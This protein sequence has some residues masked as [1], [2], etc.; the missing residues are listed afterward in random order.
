MVYTSDFRHF[1]KCR[2]KDKKDGFIYFHAM[3]YKKNMSIARMKSH[4]MLANS[5]FKEAEKQDF[6]LLWV[7]VPPNSFVKAGSK[8]KKNHQ[9]VKL[10][11]DLIDLWPE[12]MPISKFK[13]LPPFIFWKNLRDK[14][15]NAADVIVT[16]CDL[17][18]QKLP[19][20]IKEKLHT[21][22]LARKIKEENNQL[23]LPEDRISLCYLGSINNIIDIAVITD[24]IKT[25]KAYKNVEIHIVGDGEKRD[26][27]ISACENVGAEVI[28][29]GRVYEPKEKEKIFAS[30]HYGLNIMKNSVF[31]GLTMK[32][33]DYFEA[34]LPIINNIHGDT[35]NI[36]DKFNIG[37]NLDSKVDFLRIVS[38]S[39]EMR[40]NTRNVFCQLF[41]V[42]CFEKD[43]EKCINSKNF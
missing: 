5:I 10:I 9:N 30:C 3:P 37:F 21:I 26:E 29:H 12:T 28:Y 22:Y 34:G 13:S 16:E 31:V 24:L 41:S 4:W 35:W 36:I 17:Y 7:L 25:I 38:Y 19:E 43:V 40:I 15:L 6:D 14:Y 20:S 8:Y 27:L 32:S 23:S 1:E 33:I 18:H 11:F 42:E 2:R 39:Q